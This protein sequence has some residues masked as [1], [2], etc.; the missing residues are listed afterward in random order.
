MTR[1][2]LYLIIHDHLLGR[3][4]EFQVVNMHVFLN[5][6]KLM[7]LLIIILLAVY[8]SQSLKSLLSLDGTLCFGALNHNELFS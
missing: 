4:D 3:I 2:R 6:L 1:Y 5:R 8:L 7:Q